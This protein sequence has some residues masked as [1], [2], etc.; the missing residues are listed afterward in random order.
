MEVTRQPSEAHLQTVR[1]WN[2]Q[3]L[4][5]NVMSD[6]E[7]GVVFFVNGEICLGYAEYEFYMDTIE[8]NWF[9]APGNGAACLALF[10]GMLRRAYILSDFIKVKLHVSCCNTESPK[11]SKARL[12]LYYSFGF[13]ITEATWAS[14]GNMDFVMERNLHN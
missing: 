3:Y 14:P 10:L 11:A 5:S 6:Q 2:L 9:C 7:D 8:I 1:Q 12:N 4:G 13:K